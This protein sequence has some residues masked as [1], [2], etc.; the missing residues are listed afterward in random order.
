MCYKRDR[1]TAVSNV[2]RCKHRPKLLE[3]VSFRET[4]KRAKS[5]TRLRALSLHRSTALPRRA[6]TAPNGAIE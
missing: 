2:D 3:R 6:N 4:L 5:A 1:C